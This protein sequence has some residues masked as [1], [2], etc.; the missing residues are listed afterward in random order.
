MGHT[1][2]KLSDGPSG[3]YGVVSGRGVGTKRQV[4]TTGSTNGTVGDRTEL[5]LSRG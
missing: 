1:R 2:P 5:L 3:R 4:W